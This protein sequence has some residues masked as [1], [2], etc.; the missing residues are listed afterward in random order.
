METDKTECVLPLVV[1]DPSSVEHVVPI[2]IMGGVHEMVRN[3]IDHL[4]Y[5]CKTK[6]ATFWSGDEITNDSLKGLSSGDT[7]TLG[8]LCNEKEIKK[9]L[10]QENL[11]ALTRLYKGGID[12]VSNIPGT[13]RMPLEFTVGKREMLR[14]L[15]ELGVDI[16]HQFGNRRRT[17]LHNACAVSNEQDIAVL[18]QCK[19]NPTIK[20]ID[21]NTPLHLVVSFGLVCALETF[22]YNCTQS[23]SMNEYNSA[24]YVPLHYPCKQGQTSIIRKMVEFGCNPHLVVHRS[25]RREVCI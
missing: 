16:S 5:D 6:F 17:L 20:D 22:Y 7:I 11:P 2:D 1:R 24:G 14:H 13:N 19:A 21:G 15:S 8:E 18:L 4:Q 3:I 12:F 23:I 25:Y 10:M 9:A